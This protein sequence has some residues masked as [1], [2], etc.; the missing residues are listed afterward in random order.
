MA[1]VS[2]SHMIL[3]IA[4]IIVAASVVG[5]FT[6]SISRV[7]Q[8]I[9]DRGGSL[10]E[11]VRTDIQI[12]SDAGSTAV[13]DESTNNITLHIKNTGSASLPPDADG[14]DVLVDGEYETDVTV[15]VL[16][17]TDQWRPGGVVRAEIRPND[18]N[19]LDT[20]DHRVKVIVNE[21]EEVF[22]FRV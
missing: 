19:G 10:S 21:D 8:A 18:G 17:D 11:K 13:Y 12:I 7:S 3:F 15:T 14:I 6:D 16:D 5:V 4:S 22:E 2:V 1:S 20:G 9:E